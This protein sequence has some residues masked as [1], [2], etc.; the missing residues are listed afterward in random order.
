VY[1]IGIIGAPEC[2]AGFMSLGF[3]VKETRSAEDARAALREMAKSEYAVIYIT[4]ELALPLSAEIA[5]YKDSTLPAIVM[6]PGR[7]GPTG[8]GMANLKSAVERAVGVDILF[9]DE[10]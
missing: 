2:T 9:R 8:I 4:E 6:L 5:E 10:Q 3:T 1:K 7:G